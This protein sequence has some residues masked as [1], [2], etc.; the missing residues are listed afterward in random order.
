MKFT[1]CILGPHGSAVYLHVM[2]DDIKHA[3]ALVRGEGLA[4]FGRRGFSFTVRQP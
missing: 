3:R 2:A 1:A 4:T